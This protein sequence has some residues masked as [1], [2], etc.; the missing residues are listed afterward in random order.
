[1]QFGR[2]ANHAVLK[3]RDDHCAVIGALFGVALDEAVV[4]EAMEAIMP[5]VAVEPQQMIAQQRQFFLLAQRPDTAVSKRGRDNGK[6]HG[7]SPL[8]EPSE[9]A[10]N[11]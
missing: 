8:R 2:T 5:A 6:V 1:M 4:H 11:P 3:E 10:S 9:E 7:L